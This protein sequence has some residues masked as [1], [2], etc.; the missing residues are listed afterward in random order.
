MAITKGKEAYNAARALGDRSLEFAL[1]GGVALSY[2][3]IADSA[4]AAPWLERA[5]AIAAE[6]PTPLRA[7]Q[8]ESWRGLVGSSA[9]D[10]EAVHTHLSRAAQLAA[11][12]GKPAAQCETQAQLALEAARL[13]AERND[14]E[15]L[16]IAETAARE[17]LALAPLLTGHA[18]WAAQAQAAIAKV[19]LARGLPDEAAMAGKEALS[20]L[21][22][23][24]REDLNLRI[25]LPAADAILAGGN[26]E[27]S[28][29]VRER[30]QLLLP[31]V[32]Q[33]ITD[34]DIRVRWFRGPVGRDLA[35]LAGASSEAGKVE[36]QPLASRFSEEE[37]GLL[38]LLTQGRTNKEIAEETG[39]AEESIAR[40]LADLYVKI[41]VSSRAA[42]TATAVMGK[43]V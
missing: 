38:R 34:E 30:L 17:A 5:A 11:E 16:E 10:A 19:L 37:A 33:R 29:A 22:S 40:R 14:G 31:L 24:L 18:P 43:L 20:A 13:G 28:A 15:L 4:E 41:G 9:G 12:L 25:L 35:R 8:L 3:D 39:E 27:D 26:E 6:E 36:S 32:A 2:A 1:A 7:L 21:D 42:A 23:T